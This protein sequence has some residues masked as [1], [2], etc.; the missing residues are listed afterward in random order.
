MVTSTAK[1]RSSSAEKAGKSGQTFRQAFDVMEK[2]NGEN[3]GWRRMLELHALPKI[4]DKLIDDL[5]D[6]SCTDFAEIIAALERV[7]KRETARKLQQRMNRVMEDATGSND[8]P[9]HRKR[10]CRKVPSFKKVRKNKHHPSLDFAKPCPTFMRD[11]RAL[12][13]DRRPRA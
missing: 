3:P 1:T 6:R 11:L 7:G 4:G 2:R 12:P 9:A 5:T 8:T 10:I 13:R